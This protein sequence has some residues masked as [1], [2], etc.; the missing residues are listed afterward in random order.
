MGLN[1]DRLKSQ[2]SK[3]LAYQTTQGTGHPVHSWESILQNQ[4]VALY[5]VQVTVTRGLGAEHV[6]E[7]DSDHRYLA[8]DTIY[9]CGIQKMRW[10]YIS[11]YQNIDA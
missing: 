2:E 4:H 3:G 1:A 10:L 7:T 6:A 5:R 9:A 11:R 8:R